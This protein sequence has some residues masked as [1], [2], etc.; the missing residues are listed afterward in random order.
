LIQNHDKICKIFLKIFKI[1]ANCTKIFVFLFILM[2][3]LRKLRF[4]SQKKLRTLS[5]VPPVGGQRPAVASLG[6]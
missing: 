4:I 6:A 5:A 3:N 1:C 2:K